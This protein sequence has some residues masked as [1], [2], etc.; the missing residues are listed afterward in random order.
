MVNIEI[1]E[2]YHRG[3]NQIGLFFSYDE[4]LIAQVR[5]IECHFSNT[6][7]CWYI[8]HT[9]ENYKKIENL[10]KTKANCKVKPAREVKMAIVLE[11]EEIIK[12]LEVIKNIKH[13]ALIGLLYSSGLKVGE[14]INLRVEDIDGN[15]MKIRVRAS[16][17][18]KDRYVGLSANFLIILKGYYKRYQPKKYLFNGQNGEQYSVKSIRKVLENARV[19]AGIE[20]RISPQALRDSYAVHMIEE[21]IDV[22]NLQKLLGHSRQETTIKYKL[23]AE[24]RHFRM[25]SPFDQL[26]K[27]LDLEQPEMATFN[28]LKGSHYAEKLGGNGYF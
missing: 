25:L 13:K 15:Q 19:K 21:G 27:N 1:K 10:I 23:I 11:R 7:K 26:F 20:K 24:K 16:K 28:M 8:E 5:S 22:G 3:K 9:D 6:H 12:L 18:K 4:K 17:D 14:L 2:L